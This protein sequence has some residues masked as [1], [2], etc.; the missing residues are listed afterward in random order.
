MT[1]KIWFFLKKSQNKTGELE[2]LYKNLKFKI[3]YK[4]WFKK[5]KNSQ[6]KTVELEF[7]RLEFLLKKIWNLK[8]VIKCDFSFKKK[9]QNKTVELKFYKLEFYEGLDNLILEI[10]YVKCSVQSKRLLCLALFFPV[11]LEFYRL[12]FH[13]IFFFFLFC[14]VLFCSTPQSSNHSQGN[15]FFHFFPGHAGSLETEMCACT[16]CNP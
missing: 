10:K 7:Y 14:F 11:E 9:S 16:E 6:D 4:M 15:F 13:W 5:K 2:F 8:K 1:L 12:E 3:S